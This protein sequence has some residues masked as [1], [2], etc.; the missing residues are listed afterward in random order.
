MTVPVTNDVKLIEKKHAP[1]IFLFKAGV[2]FFVVFSSFYYIRHVPEYYEKLRSCILESC[3]S[4]GPPPTSLEGLIHSGLSVDSYAL[5]LVLSDLFLTFFFLLTAVIILWKSK[6]TILSY[7]AMLGM[8]AYG[9]TFPSLLYVSTEGNV[10]MEWWTEGIAGVGRIALFLFL[11]LFP[12]GKWV[13]KWAYCVF[14]PFSLIQLMNVLFPVTMF[15]LQNWSVHVRMLYYVTMICLILYLQVY[16]YRHIST[17]EEKLQT[18]WIVY[19]MILSFS[20][21]IGTSAFFVFSQAIDPILYVFYNF[22]LNLFVSIIPLTVSFGILRKRLWDI[23]PLVNRTILYGLLSLTVVI[24]YSLLVIYLGNLFKTEENFIL[25]LVATSVVAVLFTPIKE[26]LQKL[27]NRLLKGKHDDPYSV[28]AALGKQLIK[29]I[30]PGEMLEVIVK[31]VRDALRLPYVG[32]SLEIGG[33]DKLATSSGSTKHDMYTFPIIYSGEELGFLHLSSR[34][35]GEVF[36]SE[37]Y[38]LIDVMIRQTG[39]IVQNVN[40][41]LGMKLLADDLQKSREKLVLAREKE[42]LEIRR[43]LHDE[44]APRLMSLAFNVAAAQQYVKKDPET[45]NQLLEELRSVIRG[46]VEDIRSMVHGLRPPTLDEFG[47]IGSIKLR[48]QELQ[49]LSNHGQAAVQIRIEVPDQLPSLP[50]A[51]EVAAYRIVTESLVNVVRHANATH[52]QVAIKN[53]DEK[54]LVIEVTDNGI[55][56]PSHIKDMGNGIG[57]KSIRERA[58]ELSGHCVMERGKSGGTRIKATLPFS[59][60]GENNEHIT[61][62]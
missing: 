22:V 39:P 59:I 27:I 44:L 32:I 6:G 1:Y 30:S 61:C 58:A 7:I 55:G 38:K 51:I 17:S 49:Q 36:T 2:L 43:N 10:V 40:M 62:G 9:A 41:S 11:M 54:L 18:K 23:A 42:R 52:C 14:V 15:D 5:L 8:V 31:E 34:S 26:K 24:L 19:G 16:R 50:A 13:P 45:A 4:F 57:L 46:T 29:R 20:G 60:E 53:I 3:G 33:V 48:I 35:P 28:L 47:L 12:N 37:D 25:S 56:I 21:F